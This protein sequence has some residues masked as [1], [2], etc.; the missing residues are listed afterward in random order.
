MVRSNVCVIYVSLDLLTYDN[1][2]YFIKKK[3]NLSLKKNNKK[4]IKRNKKFVKSFFRY[5]HVDL[6]FAGLTS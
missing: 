1:R 2:W 4:K 3:K 5:Y 6:F